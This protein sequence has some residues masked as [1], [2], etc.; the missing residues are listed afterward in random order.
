MLLLRHIDLISHDS[1]CESKYE[2]RRTHRVRPTG[3]QRRLKFY[4]LCVLCASL[5][6]LC[7]KFF[8]WLS[9]NDK[10]S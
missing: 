10:I 4:S 9:S 8:K 6:V 1:I 5:C 2:Q 3:T 7:E